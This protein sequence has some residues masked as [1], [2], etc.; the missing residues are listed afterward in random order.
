MVTDSLTAVAGPSGVGALFLLGVFLFADGFA[1]E[2][3]PTVETYAKTTTWGIV[4]AVP[5]LA[6]TYVLGLLFMTGSVFLLQFFFGPGHDQEM[7]DIARLA[8]I[9]ADK[10]PSV[11]VYVQLMHERSVLAGSSLACLV[12]CLG[13]LSERRNL[14]NLSGSI[15]VIALGALLLAVLLFYFAGR[16]SADAHFL[17]KQVVLF[18]PTS[19]AK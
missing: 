8:S 4:A 7:V 11:Q 10:S 5:V 6:M 15:I 16:K 13:A 3:F 14:P 17:V 9:A 2:I 12:L 19:G 1:P 18:E